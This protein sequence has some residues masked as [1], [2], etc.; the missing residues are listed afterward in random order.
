MV[1]PAFL[2]E[3][4]PTVGLFEIEKE[5]QRH[6][7]Y[8][9][10]TCDSGLPWVVYSVADR[11]VFE[12]WYAIWSFDEPSETPGGRF[13]VIGG[14]ALGFEFN[15]DPARRNSVWWHVFTLGLHRWIRMDEDVSYFFAYTCPGP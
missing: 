15:D 12:F 13:L 1:S 6:D 8:V 9:V 2:A 3:A 7:R 14:S 4:T 11:K 5:Y 10:G